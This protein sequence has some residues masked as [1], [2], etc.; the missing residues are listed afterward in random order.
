MLRQGDGETRA[1]RFTF[2][3]LR[4]TPL[5]VFAISL[6]VYLLTLA[7]DLTW[8]HYGADGGDLITASFTGGVAHPPG[9]PLYLILGR[10]VALLPVGSVPYRY[11]LFSALAASGAAAMVAWAAMRLSGASGWRAAASGTSAGLS[12]AFAPLVWGQAV[13]T[14]V[15]ALNALFSAAI[16][17]LS[18]SVPRCAAHGF[19]LSAVFGLAVSHH[20]TLV[21]FLPI[22]AGRLMQLARGLGRGRVLGVSLVGFAVGLLPL[23]YLPLAARRPV[24][25]GD[26]ST[27]AGWWWLVSGRLY[28]GYA[29]AL[30][31]PQIIERVRVIAQALVASFTLLGVAA[32][33]AGMQGLLRKDALL[34]WTMLATALGSILFALGYL[35][36]DSQVYLIPMLVISTAWIGMGWQRI[37][38]SFRLPVLIVLLMVSQVAWMLIT[39]W[40]AV[41]LHADRAARDFVQGVAMQAPQRAIVITAEDRHTFALWVSAFVERPRPDIIAVDQDMLKFDWYRATLRRNFPD[42]SV[43][44]SSDINELIEQNSDRPACRPTGWPP[45]WLTCW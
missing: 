28:E 18:I 37:L 13:I 14:E 25:W 29:F 42:L 8:A 39:N 19:A 12:L 5:L 10:L 15:Y 40:Q 32:G 11:N 35:P 20:L 44:E 17:A 36:E 21:C 27:L 24:V 33:L 1:S 43:P 31:V 6:L 45:P 3:V 9:Y 41:D 4:F 7:P 30:P 16:L 26:P 22:V 23:A 38:A 34:A 2:Y